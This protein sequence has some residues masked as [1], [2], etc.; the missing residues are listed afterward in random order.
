MFLNLIRRSLNDYTA[1]ML[2]GTGYPLPKLKNEL[3]TLVALAVDSRQL[4][5]I[6]GGE[7]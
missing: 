7:A 1:A 5:G 6:L 4:C 3:E 2:E